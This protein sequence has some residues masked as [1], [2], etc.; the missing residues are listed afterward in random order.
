MFLARRQLYFEATEYYCNVNTFQ[1]SLSDPTY[2]SFEYLDGHLNLKTRLSRMR[3]LHVEIRLGILQS[4][5]APD[6]LGLRLYRYINTKSS[7][8][9]RNATLEL[10]AMDRAR[11]SYGEALMFSAETGQ[12]AFARYFHC[13]G[14]IEWLE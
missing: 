14:G 12:T 13:Q 1:L 9:P 8:V 2:S 5:Y 3:N 7:R 6:T 11:K 10:V 4:R